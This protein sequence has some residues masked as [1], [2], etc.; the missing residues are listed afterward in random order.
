MLSNKKWLAALLV[1]AIAVFALGAC[2]TATPTTTDAGTPEAAASEAAP[3]AETPAAAEGG[4]VVA[5]ALVACNPLPPVPAALKN[6]QQTVAAAQT[7]VRARPVVAN[8]SKALAP[9]TQGKIYKIG[10]FSDITSTNFWRANGPDNTVWNNYVLAPTRLFMYA[11][12]DITFQTVP[13]ASADAEVPVVVADGDEFLGTVHLRQ[14]IKWSDGTPFT[15]KDVAFTINTVLKY[16]LVSGN[17]SQWVRADYIRA[18]ETAEGDDY[19]LLV[20]FYKQPGMLV[21]E[22]GLLTGMPIMSEAFWGPLVGDDG[23]GA[24]LKGLTLPG[25]DASDDEKAAYAAASTTATEALFNLDS[26]GEPMAGVLFFE[27]WEPGASASST[28]NH[29][30]FNN[31]ATITEYVNGAYHESKA[32]VY[33]FTLYGEATGDKSLEYVAGPYIDT[34]VYFIYPDQ[35]T[36][37]LALKAG[38][39]DYMLNSVGLQ[40]ALLS[41]VQDDPNLTVVQNPYIGFRYMSFNTKRQPM[42]DCAFRQIVSTL[43]DREFVMNTILQKVGAPIYT[44]IPEANKVWYYDSPDVAKPGK[45]MS[46]EQ[47]INYAIQI[48]EAAGYKWE[49]D[50]KP[51][52]DA[53]NRQ[54]IPGGRMIM[55]NGDPM[56]DITLMAPSAGY[57]PMRA[58]FAVWVET[59][60]KEFG[61]P[62]TADLIGFNVIIDKAINQLDYDIFMLGNTGAIFPSF[63]RD[64]WHT[65]Q[66]GPGGNNSAQYSNPEFDKLSDGMNSCLTLEDC[67]EVANKLQVLVSNEMPWIPLFSLPIIEVYSNKLTF[68]YDEALSGIQVLQGLPGSVKVSE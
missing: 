12:A 50:V 47:R 33:D 64:F 49:G 56:P 34:A 48:A 2:A 45:G 28:A 61:I 7:P 35:N 38:D 19:T 22:Q 5:D 10:I 29:D 21:W 9:A 67:K 41:E 60:A 66:I 1:L 30:I 31:G 51:T 26:A 23:S 4:P 18:A 8:G 20:H 57:D 46:R 43:I 32:N 14:D 54:V 16:Q 68:P 59:W 36:A 44:F 11:L 65:D 42:N 13:V 27:K 40:R 58:T 25:P 52:W 6:S 39:I 15:A 24:A 55:P 62:L 37:V 3:V 17:W 53:D 63:M